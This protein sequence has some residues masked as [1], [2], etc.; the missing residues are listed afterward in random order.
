VSDV[1]SPK[2][3]AARYLVA[4]LRRDAEGAAVVLD[5][6]GFARELWEFTADLSVFTRDALEKAGATDMLCEWLLEAALR[7]EGDE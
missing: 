3:R 5:E 2:D 4:V 1:T 7:A 6:I